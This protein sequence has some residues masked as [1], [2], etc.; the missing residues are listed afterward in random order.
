MNMTSDST[1]KNIFLNK[2]PLQF[3]GAKSYAIVESTWLQ[4]VVKFK[5]LEYF[6]TKPFQPNEWQGVLLIDSIRVNYA[7]FYSNELM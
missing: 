6:D 4:N 3:I 5:I 7:Y 1:Y 2:I